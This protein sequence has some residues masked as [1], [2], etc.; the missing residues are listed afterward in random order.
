MEEKTCHSRLRPQ[1]YR[2]KGIY[3]LTQISIHQAV[4]SR[5]NDNAAH[6]LRSPPRGLLD[7]CS[8]HRGQTIRAL[9][10]PC[11]CE[12]D[13]SPWF[14]W[15]PITWIRQLEWAKVHLHFRLLIQ[16]AQIM[17]G[18][19]SRPSFN[20]HLQNVSLWFRLERLAQFYL[21]I[22]FTIYFGSQIVFFLCLSVVTS[23]ILKTK[24]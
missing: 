17:I 1:S 15:L 13:S 20:P 7:G 24:T 21:M 3:P 10:A 14:P 22:F 5:V 16:S 4:S 8:W 23:W 2:G 12:S 19:L 9:H 11:H 6:L 18:K